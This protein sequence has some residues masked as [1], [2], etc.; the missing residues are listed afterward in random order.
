[1]CDD[2]WLVKEKKKQCNKIIIT[3]Q[4]VRFD[5]CL[6]CPGMSGSITE[7]KQI[8]GCCVLQWCLLYLVSKIASCDQGDSSSLF[9]AIDCPNRYL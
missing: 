3:K 9:V 1:M 7:S 2:G 4:K 8:M 5:G 6:F